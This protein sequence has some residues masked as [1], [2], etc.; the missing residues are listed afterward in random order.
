[1]IQSHFCN[2]NLSKDSD[3]RI[4]MKHPKANQQVSIKSREDLIKF[5]DLSTKTLE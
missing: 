4:S 5:H 3:S 1:M 2:Q